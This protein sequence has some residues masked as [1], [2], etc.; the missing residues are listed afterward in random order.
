VTDL[1]DDDWLDEDEHE[2]PALLHEPWPSDLAYLEDE[3]VWVA[4]R[5]ERIALERRR[6]ARGEGRTAPRASFALDEVD[7]MDDL[8][9]EHRVAMVELEE[10]RAR[11]WLDTRLR[12]HRE[13]GFEL[14]LDRVVRTYGLDEFERKVLLVGAGPCVAR[15]YE[16]LYAGLGGDRLE[17]LTVDAC[18]HFAA[19][20]VSERIARRGVL[21]PRGRLLTSGLLEAS[22]GNAPAPKDLLSTELTL[23]GRTFS[24]MLGDDRLGDELADLARLEFPRASFDRVVLPEDSRR[25]ILTVIDDR[26]RVLEA[27]KRWGLEGAITYGRGTVLLFDGPPGTGKTL[28]AHAIA[29]RLGA[30][31][32]HVDVASFLSHS[33]GASFVPLIFREACLQRALLFFDECDAIFTSRRA[34]NPLMHILLT[35]LERFEGTCV[36]A[37]NLPDLLDDALWRR[38]LVRVHFERP[39][40]AARVALWRAHLPPGL[41]LSPDVDL[42]ALAE[43]ELTGGAIKNAVLNAA[44]AAVHAAQSLDSATVTQAMLSAAAHEQGAGRRLT[45]ADR[46]R[47]ARE[48]AA[49]LEPRRPTGFS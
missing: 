32:L 14:G 9:L 24:A 40:R 6:D 47:V 43:I 12:A 38:A 48:D 39:D 46:E 2:D 15:R 45:R 13:L 42:D 19:L 1:E 16:R 3:L 5:C 28:C 36:L 7:R 37:T 34:G 20:S 33:D 8:A 4:K 27:R 23:R 11:V 31:V 26:E 30:R 21:G 35:E 49:A 41:P 44:A 22:F 10:S 17:S 18:F 25:R 29:E